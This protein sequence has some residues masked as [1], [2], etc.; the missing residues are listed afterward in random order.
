MRACSVLGALPRSL[1]SC[2]ASSQAKGIQVTAAAHSCVRQEGAVTCDALRGEDG[3]G[4]GD[5]AVRAR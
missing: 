5:D 3:G 2:S 4:G 1:S